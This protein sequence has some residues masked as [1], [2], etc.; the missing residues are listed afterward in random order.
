LVLAQT[1][2][3]VPDSLVNPVEEGN[4]PTTL[5]MIVL[6][7]Y[8][9]IAGPGLLLKLGV[10]SLGLGLAERVGIVLPTRPAETKTREDEPTRTTTIVM[11]MS[12][13]EFVL[14]VSLFI[15]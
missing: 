11:A 1:P 5:P 9:A 12:R 8:A 2:P 7:E 4:D 6:G 14:L 13:R 15:R 3:D 10:N